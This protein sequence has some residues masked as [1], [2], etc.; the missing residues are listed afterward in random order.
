MTWTYALVSDNS[1]LEIY[2]ASDTLVAT[3][4]N[5]GTGFNVKA[6]VLA[7]IESAALAE[8]QAN[9]FSGDLLQLLRDA[10]FENI[11]EA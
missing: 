5:D 11:Q 2:D 1:E 6:E 3:V 4:P 10:I 9:G 7:E 8:Y